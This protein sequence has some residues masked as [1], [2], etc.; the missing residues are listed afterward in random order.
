M[1]IIMLRRFLVTW[2]S[3]T[4]RNDIFGWGWTIVSTSDLDPELRTVTD[5]ARGKTTLHLFLDD[6][7]RHE[8]T[9]ARSLPQFLG[10]EIGLENFIHDFPADTTGIMYN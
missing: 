3:S 6:G 4:Q 8:Q 9:Y 7:F 5:V 2:S 10:G 1:E